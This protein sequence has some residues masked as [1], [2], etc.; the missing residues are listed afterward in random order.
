MLMNMNRLVLRAAA[1]AGF[2][3]LSVAPGL[4]R[5]QV[6]QPALVQPARMAA[7]AARPI[8][9]TR[10]TD[11][12][13]GLKFTDDQKA[14]ID[15]IHR[16]TATRKDVVVKSETLNAEQKEAM[17]AGLGRMERGEIVKL[18]TPEQQREV[19]KKAHAGQGAAPEKKQS[20]S[21]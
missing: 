15:E 17:I 5:A 12:F 18:L 4:M 13:A 9:D 11:E 2:F 14:K 10:I 3:F 19:L 20:L 7:P 16:R 8:R 21:Q 1:V 6:T